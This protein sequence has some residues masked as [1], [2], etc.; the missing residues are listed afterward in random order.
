MAPALS[1]HNHATTRPRTL[2]HKLHLMTGTIT[3]HRT[4]SIAGSPVKTV[5]IT[6]RTTFKLQNS[7]MH[8]HWKLN[9]HNNLYALSR[10][11]RTNS[12]LNNNKH[13]PPHKA[14]HGY[15]QTHHRTTS[16][17]HDPHLGTPV[18]PDN[19]CL[20]RPGIGTSDTRISKQQYDIVVTLPLGQTGYLSKLGALLD[21]WA[22]PS[23]S[24]SQLV[25]RQTR[26]KNSF[27]MPTTIQSQLWATTISTTAC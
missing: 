14:K 16:I 11:R 10:S 18:K 15:H 20:R 9:I 26:P 21:L 1:H 7:T 8:S 3:N 12:K 24:T 22:S 6:T 27:A 4:E 2:P 19:L 13:S 5:H 25:W 17:H 23:Y